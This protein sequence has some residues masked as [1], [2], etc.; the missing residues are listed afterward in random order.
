MP[1]S[2]APSPNGMSAKS[3]SAT[4]ASVRTNMLT[5]MGKTNSMTTV[6]AWR[7]CVCDSIHAA[8]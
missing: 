1:K 2:S 3:N 5:H 4:V 6:E 8:G 7:M